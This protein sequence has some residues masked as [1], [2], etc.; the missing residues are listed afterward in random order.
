[1]PRYK[2]NYDFFKYEVPIAEVCEL[3]GIE[4]A[5]G[6]KYHSPFHIDKNPS[7]SITENESSPYFNKWKD[8]SL[9]IS[10]FSIELVLA[11]KYNI[12]PEDYY[13]NRN[14][15]KKEYFESIKYLNEYF[16]GGIKEIDI[17]NQKSFSNIPQIP[18]SIIEKIGLKRNP[19][20]DIR[21]KGK[22]SKEDNRY[23]RQK[24][25]EIMGD[26]YD[27][28]LDLSMADRA[29]ILLDAL[30]DYEKYIY[31]YA[32]QVIKDFPELDENA[33]KVIIEKTSKWINI[34]HPYTEKVKDYYFEMAEKE[35]PAIDFEA[36]EKEL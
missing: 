1:M 20:M 30:Q 17:D 24:I 22:L 21:E 19:L 16:P 7:F 36:E 25:K 8:W 32:N 34:I 12:M 6:N 27:S 11:V 18:Q 5:G 29:S 23:Y 9:N 31:R 14:K 13:K 4:R 28:S 33:Q 26:K 15:Y 3:L 35:F 10:G 2:I